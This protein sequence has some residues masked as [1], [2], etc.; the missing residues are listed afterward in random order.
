MTMTDESDLR[1]ALEAASDLPDLAFDPATVLVQG[2]RTLRRRRLVAAG[3]GVAAAA[4]V[5]VA[6]AQAAGSLRTAPPLPAV[7]PTYA[8]TATPQ[9]APTSMDET[10]A[11][12]KEGDPSD[13]KA[14]GRAQLRVRS[15]SPG[16]VAETWT[17]SAGGRT[18]TVT[19]TVKALAEGEFSLLMPAE[20][21]VPHTVFG[22]LNAGSLGSS[23]SQGKSRIVALKLVTHGPPVGSA[24]GSWGPLQDTSGT[25]TPRLLFVHRRTALEASDVLGLSWW[26]TTSSDESS[27][28]P[29]ATPWDGRSSRVAAGRVA[30]AADNSWILWS[31]GERVGVEPDYGSEKSTGSLTLLQ[32]VHSLHSPLLPDAVF[33]WVTNT[34]PVSVKTSQPGVTF[35]VRYTEPV[36]GQ[37]GFVATASVPEVTGTVTVS[38]GGHVVSLESFD[39]LRNAAPEGTTG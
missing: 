39:I 37:R 10:G 28:L 14:E 4:V 11:V 18:R 21:G 35:D 16:L 38:A 13:P 22:Y 19:R 29:H 26:T 7:P 24:G 20:S 27:M 17:V 3:L 33:G 34:G 30:D 1:A 8:P 32:R 15:T 9:P 31:D 23:H 12:A 25:P 2:H 5:A 36:N 6:A